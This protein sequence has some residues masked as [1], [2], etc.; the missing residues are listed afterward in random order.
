MAARAFVSQLEDGI[1]SARLDAVTLQALAQF[2]T[3][4]ALDDAVRVVILLGD[5]G[6]ISV[7]DRADV[8]SAIEGLRSLPQPIIAWVQGECVGA[9][10]ELVE[11][12][13]LVMDADA[14]EAQTYQ[15]ARALTAK[16]PLALRF[17]KR[18]LQQ[19]GT[20]GWDDILAF[21]SAQQQEIKALQAGRPSARAQ[22]IES[23]LAGKTK[24]GKTESES[25]ASA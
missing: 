1:L 21:T 25:G 6:D 2:C 11:A 16:D 14:T 18:T 10:S 15:L 19:V 8:A 3:E 23:F 7:D 22:A 13:D 12:C 4:T 9:A 24:P 17:T 5:A 20:V